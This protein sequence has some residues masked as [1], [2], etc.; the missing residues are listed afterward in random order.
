MAVE[1]ARRREVTRRRN[2]RKRKG[3]MVRKIRRTRTR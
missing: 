1:E 3:E 2:K